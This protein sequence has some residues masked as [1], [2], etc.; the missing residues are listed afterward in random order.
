M[1]TDEQIQNDVIEELRWEPVLNAC[2]IGVSVRNGIVTL[3]G[4][5]DTYNKK[6][7][8]EKAATRIK[9]TK[10]VALDI[11][12]RTGENSK[13]TD[14]EIAA[15]VLNALKW[16]SGV[17][18]N[19][20][21]VLV[22]DGWV[23]LSGEVEW[24]FERTAAVKAVENLTG[25]TGISSHIKVVPAVHIKDVRQKISDAFHRNATIDAGRIIIDI[26][27]DRIVLKGKVKSL[28]EK[29]EAA[30][31]AWLTPGVH[32]IENRLEVEVPVYSYS[33]TQ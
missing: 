25:V 2:E 7:L 8:A 16:H 23:I 26:V 27:A 24:D 33:G 4:T 12:V 18:E 3:S 1:K 6:V 11:I 20:I 15:A 22:E 21:K 10:A 5:V 19:Q 30:N 28:A 9:G 14:A 17:K 32:S 31:A 29:A 13:K